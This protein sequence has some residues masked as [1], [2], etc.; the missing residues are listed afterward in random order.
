[1]LCVLRRRRWEARGQTR[2][3]HRGPWSEEPSGPLGPH[4]ERVYKSLKDGTIRLLRRSWLCSQV[5]GFVLSRRQDLPDNAYYSNDEAAR[6]FSRQG[7]LIAVLSYGWLTAL[8]CDPH[9]L[10]ARQLVTFLNS[11]D[12]QG[13]EALFWDFA[14]LMQKGHDGTP[15][16][17]EEE[18]MFKQ[19]TSL[20]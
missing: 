7:R 17:A 8:H 3:S 19:V 9:G 5:E 1:M 11:T 2:V 10:H 4:D 13:F 6:L 15:R 16:T 18:A 20:V 12:G 14:S